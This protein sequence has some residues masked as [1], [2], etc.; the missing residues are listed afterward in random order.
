MLGSQPFVPGQR[1]Q[2]T[3]PQAQETSTSIFGC[4]MDQ[5]PF[6]P[7]QNMCSSMG[8][9]T[10]GKM[11]GDDLLSML[12]CNSSAGSIAKRPQAPLSQFE[13]SYQTAF[14]NS[15]LQSQEVS[16]MCQNFQGFSLSSQPM[17]FQSSQQSFGH[18]SCGYEETPKIFVPE[19]N[20]QPAQGVYNPAP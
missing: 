19:H 6:S 15:G 7:A 1:F 11:I 5:Q 17:S 8:T 13:P 9:S 4:Q 14:S 18:S 3:M 2:P 12:N 20:Q 10:Q 16:D